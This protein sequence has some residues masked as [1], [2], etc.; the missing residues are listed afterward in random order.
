M[1]TRRANL[2][3][4][5]CAA[6]ALAASAQPT[7]ALGSSS[8]GF[9]GP[10]PAGAPD[11]ASSVHRAEQAEQHRLLARPAHLRVE[12]MPLL[13]ALRELGRRS[14]VPLA[15]SPSLLP[16]EREVGCTCDAVTVG[17]ALDSLLAGTGVT[18][19]ESSGQVILTSPRAPAPPLPRA[20]I[21]AL[22]SLASARG[23][24]AE[25]AEVDERRLRPRAPARAPLVRA[26]TITGRVTDESGTPL[27]DVTVTSQ[28]TGLGAMTSP[29]GTYRMVV[30]TERVIA[31]PDTLRFERLGY[32]T[33]RV[34]YTL[35]DGAVR[36]DA[37]MPIQAVAL[38]EVLVTGTA[39]NQERRAQS[40]VVAS[41]DA[42][43]L[44]R[45]APITNVTQL[46]QSRL[47]GINA[48]ESS[49]TTGA[50]ARIN[51]RGAASI[52]LSNQPLVFVDGVRVDGGARGLVNVSGAATVGQ[53]P[54]ALNDL[55]TDDIERIE[56]VKGP[57]AAT[58]YGADAS[59]GVIQI[60]TKRGQV[61]SRAFSQQISLEYD[62]IEPNFDV[63]TNFAPCPAGL[64][65][66]DS[67]NPL[68]RGQA[69]GTV[70]SD[71]PAERLGMFESGSLR[72]LN[73]NA[74]GG[75]E[76]YGYFA[77]AALADEQGTTPNNQLEQRSGRVNFTFTPTS[78]LVF[79]ANFALSRTEYELPRSDQDAYGYYLQSILGSPLT[80]QEGDEGGLAGGLLFGTSTLES[81]SSIVSR[82]SALR[83]TPSV[84]V[85]F[86]PLDWFTNRF[87]VGA[88]L[89]QGE[90]F[91]L[92]PKN[93]QG[94]Y[95]T[96]VGAGNGDF[97]RTQQDDR[98]YTVDYLGNI[99]A[100]FGS[101]DDFS[102]NLSF[103]S[104]Y[105]HRLTQSL[106]GTGAGLATNQA[107]LVTNAA[108]STVGQGFGESKSFGLFVQEQ[109]G[110]RD[111][112][113]VQVG[114]RADRNSA[115][116]SEVGTFYLPKLGASY[117]ISEESFWEPLA[118]AVPTM[119]LR[120]AY[121]TTGRSPASGAALQT[122]G[123]AKYVTDAG[124]LDLGVVP[125]NPGNPELKPERGKELEF[126]FD[127]G[128]FDD[129]LG[130]EVTYFLKRS[131]DLLVS[132]PVAPSTGFGSPPFG[133]IGEV[134][135]RGVEFSVRATPVSRDDLAWD[136]ALTGNTLHNEIVDLATDTFINNFRAFVPGRQIASWWVHRIRSIDEAA[137]QVIV[138]DGAEFAGNQLP[139]FQA[140]L[141]STLTL[142]QRVRVNALFERKSGYYVLNLN[143]EFR[144]RS[145]RSS[146]DVSLSPDEGG[147]SERERL[148]RLG[149]Y[150]AEGSGM[151][152]GVANVKEP[153]LQKGDH[154]RFRELT[155]TLTLPTSWI[156]RLG[157]S[158]GTLTVG[159]RNLA[160]WAPDYEG[161]DP[162]VIGTGPQA[163][164]LNQF[165]NADVFTVPPSRRWVFR[166]NLQY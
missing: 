143:Q 13:D 9:V 37:S 59:A 54:S 133:N 85:R 52:S 75:G 124:V 67:P 122:Y 19:S 166:L 121:G 26:A 76:N 53:V 41:I 14:G 153:Y 73:Y 65:G 71:N 18:V 39:G 43:R 125:G 81:L 27:V 148:R 6:L 119:R 107:L 97:T 118:G 164:G 154:I 32:A 127:A 24:T 137:G 82:V 89:T 8:A 110:Y 103:G 117:V 105:I 159:G 115:F 87:T 135:N 111:R 134:V 20:G 163:T 131:T 155:A 56:V 63:P 22:A 80:V 144:D 17:D 120:V 116:G 50:A 12:S 165:F 23:T 101:S 68:C 91:Q 158:G 42:G 16:D 72:S 139:T 28:R 74:R 108:V 92:F 94:W 86:S 34:P 62:V 90:G 114:L 140:N 48:V 58:L 49:G 132:V 146:A 99:R 129:R 4:M 112:L 2:L 142:F 47:P 55:N 157:A 138:S 102:S 88:D 160:L 45:E 11:V 136:L 30:P 44:V 145:A 5:T 150:V 98:T 10:V 109:L 161:P 3:T 147:Y 123:I 100:D 130:A 66:A 152:V 36:V 156:G 57:A 1:V 96:R 151:P 79:D 31:G 78:K 7:V 126:G 46:L 113:F 35:S 51:I 69:E 61:G 106:S 77:S 84:Q 25:V 60:I 93:D 33:T 104:Q 40:A 95:P 83:V 64:V 141:A 70:V 149:P 128:F 38:D 29:S 21:M 162:D 15:Y